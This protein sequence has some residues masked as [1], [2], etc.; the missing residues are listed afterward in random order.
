MDCTVVLP[1]GERWETRYIFEGGKVTVVDVL[2]GNRTEITYMPGVDA[3]NIR[4]NLGRALAD[5]NGK[6]FIGLKE[7][8]KEQFI[9]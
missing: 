8:P 2:N 6:V 5:L 3:E 4:E 1:M 7:V 9:Y